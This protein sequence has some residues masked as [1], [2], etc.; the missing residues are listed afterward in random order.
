MSRCD[1]VIQ[2]GVIEAYGATGKVDSPAN[3]ARIDAEGLIVAPG[4]LDIQINGGFGHDFTHESGSIWEVGARLPKFGVTSFL[5][6]VVTSGMGERESMLAVLAA[7]PP[8]GF[9]GAMPFGTHF[10]GPF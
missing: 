9:H 3:A 4:L 7:G 1:I 2:D 8:A 10:E 6:T 5:P